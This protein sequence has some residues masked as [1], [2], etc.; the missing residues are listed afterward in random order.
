MSDAAQRGI[1]YRRDNLAREMHRN[2]QNP[3]RHR[4]GPAID[5][6]GVSDFFAGLP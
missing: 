3:P 1:V 2:A 6:G 5:I 4:L